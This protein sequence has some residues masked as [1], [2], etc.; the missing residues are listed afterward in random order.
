MSN[1]DSDK[2]NLSNTGSDSVNLSRHARLARL[3]GMQ[4]G[5]RMAAESLRGASMLDAK[6]KAL[7]F[8]EAAAALTGCMVSELAILNREIDILERAKNEAMGSSSCD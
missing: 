5:L 8:S 3:W 6:N 7:E 1:L 2:E 4:Q